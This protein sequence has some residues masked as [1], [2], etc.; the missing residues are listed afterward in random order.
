MNSGDIMFLI[1]IS[2]VCLL[3]TAA[4]SFLAW[5]F[6][7][8]NEIGVTAILCMFLQLT[9]CFLSLVLLYFSGWNEHSFSFGHLGVYYEIA[10]VFLSIISGIFAYPVASNIIK[11]NSLLKSKASIFF[12]LYLLL[13]AL[14]LVSNVHISN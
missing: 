2:L 1:L 12:V 4:I 10:I 3:P 11:N 14:F 6:T 8:N 7:K 5:L 9:V 13:A